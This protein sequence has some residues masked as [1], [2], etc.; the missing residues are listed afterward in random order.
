MAEEN[1][2]ITFSEPIYNR[3]FTLARRRYGDD[4]QE[5]ITK[6]IVDAYNWVVDYFERH[7]MT[8][9]EQIIILLA[10][11]RV[12]LLSS[13]ARGKMLSSYFRE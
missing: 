13:R 3:V 11:G 8:F 12:P 7:E 4:S 6:V 5:S 10:V 1:I 9:L 2:K